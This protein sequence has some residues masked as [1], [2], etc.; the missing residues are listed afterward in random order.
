MYPAD[1][2]HVRGPGSVARCHGVD[3]SEDVSLH[4]THEVEVGFPLGHVA[5]VFDEV[6]DVRAVVHGVLS[7]MSVGRGFWT[8]EGK[9]VEG[10]TYSF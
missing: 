2:L 3:D 4:H 7:N 10:H 6:H 5:E 8:A 9:V 1:D